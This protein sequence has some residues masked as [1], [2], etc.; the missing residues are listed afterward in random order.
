MSSIGAG[1]R[2]PRGNTGR[3]FMRLKPRIRAQTSRGPDHPGA[4]RQSWQA[5]PASAIFLQNP[6]PIRIGGTLTKSQYQFTLQSPDIDELYTRR[7]SFET[8]LREIPGLLQ[9]VTSDL[10]ITN[11]QVIVDDRP[12][13]GVS[14]AASPRS[15]S[16][17]PSTT[18]TA[19]GRFP[20]SYAPTNQYQVIMELLPE[21][22]P[23]PASLAHA[24]RPFD[25]PANWCR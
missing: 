11:P 4:A 23:D 7:P 12:R 6:P 9:D 15:R 14:A 24:V 5:S 21:Y 13:Q 2:T 10:Q 17:T 22:Q 8:K 1:G 3:I 16:K 19:H 25:P 18:P 20:P